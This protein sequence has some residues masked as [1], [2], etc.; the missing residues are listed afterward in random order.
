MVNCTGTIVEV[1]CWLLNVS[2][3]SESMEEGLGS[4]STAASNAIWSLTHI[5]FIFIVVSV[6]LLDLFIFVYVCFVF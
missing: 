1:S 3:N 6:N 4:L 5:C 2:M